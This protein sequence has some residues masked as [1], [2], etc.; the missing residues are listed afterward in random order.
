M[1]NW[2][3]Q[4]F[5]PRQ[6]E[7]APPEPLALQN[8]LQSL[9]V[10]MEERQRTIEHLRQEVER[11]RSREAQMVEETTNTRLEGL[12]S[13][14]AGPAAQILTQAD[15]LEN[16]GKPVQARDVIAVARRMLRALERQGVS[17][18]GTIGQ[19]VAFDP[20]RHT[21]IGSNGTPQAGQMVT[22][23]FSGVVYRGRIIHK[24][25]VE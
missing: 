7:A 18:E 8:E 15:L 1:S 16:Q 25:V 3:K 6:E 21:P 23:R 5:G 9:R 14:L 12:V 13:D 19:Q 2:F 24:G 17:F 20:N 10:E 11:L 22:L 4:L